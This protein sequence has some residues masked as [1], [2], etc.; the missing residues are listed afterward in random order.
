[1]STRANIGIPLANG[2]LLMIY[3]H[4]D[5]NP[6][7]VGR[8]LRNHFNS[9]VDVVKLLEGNDIRS[10]SYNDSN[11]LVVERF[12]D[13][14]CQTYETLDQAMDGFDYVY[15]FKDGWKC[16]GHSRRPMFQIEEFNIPV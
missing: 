3:S 5:G 8:I 6:N 13:G 12:N 9:F 15:L 7:H 2:K 1:M 11:N 16:Y 4:Y 10:F 14:G